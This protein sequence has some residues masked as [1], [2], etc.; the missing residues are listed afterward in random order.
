MSDYYTCIICGKQMKGFINPSHLRTKH[1]MSCEEYRQL[2]PTAK[3]TLVTAWNKGLTKETSASMAKSSRSHK[4]PEY[5][6]RFESTMLAKHGVKY[7]VHNKETMQRILDSM[8]KVM[9]EKYG[10]EN[11]GQ[12]D[13]ARKA[14]SRLGKKAM[15]LFHN[16]YDITGYRTEYERMFHEM[17]PSFKCNERILTGVRPGVVG[18]AAWYSPDFIDEKTMTIYEIDGEFHDP[19]H[20][21]RKDEFF[22]SIGYKV[23]RYSNEEVAEMYEQW[24]LNSQEQDIV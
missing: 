23:I 14:T 3:F 13:E 17:N 21:K 16:R 18:K 7:A 20:D 6:Q 12:T 5:R 4:T 22:Q 1:N 9:L 8:K 2:D 11:W 10:V 19:E 24:R 15:V